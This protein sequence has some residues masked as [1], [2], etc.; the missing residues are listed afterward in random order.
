MKKSPHQDFQFDVRT[1]G[2]TEFGKWFNGDDSI[3]MLCKWEDLG[4]GMRPSGPE[5]SLWCPG[6]GT[7]RTILIH[8]SAKNIIELNSKGSNLVVDDPNFNNDPIQ[9]MSGRAIHQLF[10]KNPIEI[11]D[12][13]GAVYGDVKYI[14]RVTDKDDEKIQVSLSGHSG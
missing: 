14:G 13:I 4:K 1:D 6:H 7:Y 8:F 5:S 12:F 3:K 11:D 2:V 10:N 9:L